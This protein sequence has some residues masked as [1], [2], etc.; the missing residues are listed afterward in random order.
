MTLRV[1]FDTNVLDYACRPERFPKDHRQ[2]QLCKVRDALAS[3]RI[4]GF[5]PV[6]MLTIEGIMRK[7]RAEVLGSTKLRQGAEELSVT[8]N[9]DLP[10]AIRAE[11]NGADI[12]TVTVNF[13]VEQSARKPLHPEVIARVKAAQALGLRVL[14]DVPRIGAFTIN[15][16]NNEFYLDNGDE[17]ALADWTNK[18]HEVGRAIE[19]RG[20]GIAQVKA[21]GQNLALQDPGSAWF[22]SL[23]NA[24]DIHQER[25]VE[26]AF[27]EWADG[28]AIASHIAYG[29]DVF[30]SSDVGNS[31][32]TNSVLDP[33]NRAWLT[34]AYGVRFMTFDDLLASLP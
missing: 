15:D 28:D 5:Y 31:N 18:V 23:E 32:A 27:G 20:L 7:D 26:R 33:A 8:R 21:L 24:K 22:Q 3:K 17:K 14:K 34:T 25:A 12:E 4:Q 30:C 29:I 2:P 10:D 13:T 19:H 6:T 1:T 9:A 16:P 11:A